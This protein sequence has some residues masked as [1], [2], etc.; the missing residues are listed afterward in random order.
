MHRLRSN[1]LEVLIA[2]FLLSLSSCGGGGGGGSNTG[3][4]SVMLTGTVTY[5]NY[6]VN[7][8]TGIDYSSPTEKPIREAVAVLQN[9]SGT[10]LATTNTTQTGGYSFSAPA[11]ST[12]RVVVKAAL[13][14]PALPR[15]T[16]VDNTNGG[17]LYGTYFD[18]ATG[19]AALTANF[20][21]NSGWDGASY[22]GGRAAAPFAVLDTVYQAEAL[23]KSADPAVQFPALIV[24]W[25][26]NNKSATGDL[27]LG[28]I[29][30]S[31]YDGNG[32]LYILGAE[33]LD[34][35]EYDTHVMAH[36][37]GH[38]FED[39]LGR[40]DNIGEAHSP[41]DI[42][43]PRVAFGEGWGNALSGM[44]FDDPLYIDTGGA[45]QATVNLSMNLD[46]D[47][48]LD[49][50]TD[51]NGSLID[52]FYSEASVQEVLYDLFD[53]GP[54]DDDNLSLGFKPI[55]DVMVGGQKTTS[56]YTT[57]F[58]FLKYLKVANPADSAAIDALAAAEN[59]D[60]GNEYEASSAPIY[61]VVPVNGT[62]VTTDVDG[63]ALQT[64]DTYGPIAADD[65]G[66][67]LFNWM[68]FRFTISA[69]GSHTIEVVPTGGGNVLLELNEK[70]TKTEVDN[71]GTGGT[72]TLTKSFTAGDYV[73][74]V[75]SLGGQASF[76][77][78]IN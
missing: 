58:S 63:F 64:W 77:V 2:L 55:Y 39:K 68:F 17:A 19:T 62:I 20:N 11:N 71:A 32:N 60:S 76:T 38:Y 59:I 26:K 67:K 14:S 65:P 48:V 13:G 78:R 9:P 70:G 24:N 8:T 43:D 6:S 30:T 25:S 10:V 29:T 31:H 75:G 53:S 21:A 57:I 74:S 66:N 28:E 3:N 69:A 44:V 49:S 51:T 33:N 40:S 61:T 12:V 4:T 56:A 46:D 27:T 52:G 23:I 47:S 35:D 34:T 1:L 41:G 45:S 22:S 16:V 18:V 37:W 5:T 15:V 36:E 42:L 54:S 50:Q 72:E 73:M 7:Q